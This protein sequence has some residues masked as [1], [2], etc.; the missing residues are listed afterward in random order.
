VVRGLIAALVFAMAAVAPAFGQTETEQQQF[1]A[2]LRKLG[3]QQGPGSGKIADKASIDIPAGHVFLGAADTSRFLTLMKNL[4][5]GNNYLFAPDRLNWFAVFS[6]DATGYIKDDE[7]IDADA[8]LQALK[9]GNQRANEER[10]KQGIPTLLLEGWF[11]APHYD[12][13][14]RRLEWATRLKT[15]RNETT[16]NYSIRLLGRSGVMNATLVTDPEALA[17]DVR[18]FKTSL[19]GYSF[20]AGERYAEFRAGDKIA[21]YGLTGLIVGGAAVAAAKGGLFKMLGKFGIYIFAGAVA[22]FWA[23]VRKLLGRN[24]TA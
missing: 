2:E 8:V 7:K 14:T 12:E 24:K 17:N 1:F 6:F 4:P 22:L 23:V 15:D 21:E 19:T 18:A 3:W 20:D 10:K 16:V 5:S 11:I 13:Q 9:E